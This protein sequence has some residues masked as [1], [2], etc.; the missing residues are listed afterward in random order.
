LPPRASWPRSWPR[1]RSAC[2]RSRCVAAALALLAGEPSRQALQ[3]FVESQLAP[4]LA[5]ARGGRPRAADL[6]RHVALGIGL[7]LALVVVAARLLQ[8]RR[9]FPHGRA[10][11]FFL[12]LA[13]VASLPI[14]LS[15]RLAGHYFFPSTIFFALGA[16]ALVIPAPTGTATHGG[17]RRRLPIALAGALAAATVLTLA[18]HGPVEPRDRELVRSLDAIGPFIRGGETIGACPASATHWG[19]Q[20][21]LQRFHRIAIVPDGTADR[22]W[23]ILAGDTCPPPPGCA[24]ALATPSFRWLR[25]APTAAVAGASRPR[26]P[27]HRAAGAAPGISTRA[28]PG[29]T[30]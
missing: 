10:A 2:S 20:S 23:F 1:D 16:A 22:Q 26:L 3:A 13:A 28:A 29:R 30:S 25:C 12:G 5:G 11:A 19:L 9:T 4:T 17:R 18:I 14:A 27:H 24:Q 21:Y 15:P 8:R 6:L 7:R